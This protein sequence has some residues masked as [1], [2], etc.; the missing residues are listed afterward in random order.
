MLASFSAVSKRQTW[1]LLCFFRSVTSATASVSTISHASEEIHEKSPAG[2]N[3]TPLATKNSLVFLDSLAKTH[4][5]SVHKPQPSEADLVKREI[6]T[7][8]KNKS[9]ESL[10]RV[11]VK[12]TSVSSDGTWQSVLTHNELSYLVNKIVNHQIGLI[13][14]AGTSIMVHSNGIQSLSSMAPARDLREKV[15]S[16]YS[17]LLYGELRG[18]LY[19]RNRRNAVPA[20]RLSAL[21]YENLISM[22]LNNGKL[23]LASK[24]F[25]RMELQFSEGLYYQHMTQK[26]WLLKFQVYSGGLSSLWK[27]EPT[28]LYE[29]EVNPR[30]SRFK[31]EKKWLDVFDDFVCHQELLLASSKVI[32]DTNLLTVM[33]S[34]MA[35]SNNVA[36]VTKLVE[37]NWGISSRG[38][39]DSK[40]SKPQQGDPLFPTLDLVQTVVVSMIYN[41]EYIS[42]LAYL[43]AFQEHYNIDLS[44]SKHCWDQLFRWSEI[45]TRFSEFRALQYFIKQ[46]ATTLYKPVDEGELSITLEEAQRSVDFDYEGYLKFVA[47]LTNQR[48]KLIGELWKGYHQ[49]QPGFSARVYLTYLRLL[50]EN[51]LDETA[52]EYL[53]ALALEHRL[54][55][56][57]TDSFNKSATND[58]IYK[59]RTL[60]SKGMKALINEKG[61]RGEL[62]QIQ[63]LIRKWSLDDTM[64][65]RLGTWATSQQPRFLEA[66]NKKNLTMTGEEEEDGFLG[67]MS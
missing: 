25:Q 49:S 57:S 12:W 22:E 39:M 47:D 40:F 67:L 26:L 41:K 63:P 14:K 21:D 32:F 52:Y 56:V 30:R 1:P 16:I 45:T 11:L 15:R 54:H 18:H 10:A 43:N 17:N 6:S 27:V 19:L 36:Q 58:T 2:T 7:L 28:D 3:E 60:Y 8:L 66:M 38:K 62:W 61:M 64:R 31:A 13:T 5:A 23:D 35:H 65:E 44:E 9:F 46:T 51:P 37:Q 33:L 50:E 42:G 34:S 29:L 55:S 24:W 20:F 48:T 59:I 53:S 4:F